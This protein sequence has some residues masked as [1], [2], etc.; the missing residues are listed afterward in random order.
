MNYNEAMQYIE[1]LGKFGIH[2]G[3]ERITGLVELLDHP[4]RKIRTIHITG[5]NG[6][7][8]VASYLSHILTASGKKTACYTSPHFVKYNERMSIDG[9]DISDEDFAAVTEETKAAV[10][11]FLKNGG[12]QPTQFEVITAMAF[13]Y[14]AKEKVDYAVIEVGMGGLWDS[15]NVIVPELS[16]ITN[17]TLEHTDRL[18]KTIEAIAEQKAGII[19][20]HVPVV[21]AADGS[22]LEVIRVTSEEK[23][24][25]L[26]VYGEDFSAT[27]LAGSM[28]EQ[29]F[30]YPFHSGEREV[31][32]HLAGAHQIVN[33]A[34]ALKAAEVLAKKDPAITEKKILKGMDLTT[35]PGRMEL[36]HERPDVILDGAHNPSGVTV[37]RR[38]LDTYY[39]H[40]HRYFIFGMMG[41]KDVSEVGQILFRDTDT[42]Y[43][44]LADNGTRAEKPDVLARRLHKKAIP[45]DD[46]KTAF[47]T[48]VHEAG[49]DDVVLV[50]GSLYLVGT[51]KAKGLSED[52]L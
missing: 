40:G 15:T 52:F 50:C 26:Y 16:V 28:Q 9:V 47:E 21:T 31:T 10:D 20:D 49:P 34:V 43:T 19:K 13:L 17:V 39:P 23:S 51:F 2:L 5:T 3:M 22:A 29:L 42:I 18:G 30:L 45:M 7:G 35:W 4:E 44:V 25:P 36:I 33:A 1:S 27:L 14:F 37:L 24:A 48:A 8:S 11:T 6:K 32:I 38:A 41:D 12:E 46:L